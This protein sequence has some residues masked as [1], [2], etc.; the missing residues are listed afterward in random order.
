[1]V[2]SVWQ[3][4]RIATTY[5]LNKGPATMLIHFQIDVVSETQLTMKLILGIQKK[6]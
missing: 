4:V 2:L 6:I 5:G 1:M 3:Y